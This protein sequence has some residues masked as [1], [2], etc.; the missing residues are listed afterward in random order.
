MSG[1]TSY[2]DKIDKDSS[3][4]KAHYGVFG[5]LT[6]KALGGNQTNPL[7]ST[8]PSF[9][10]LTCKYRVVV[11]VL[12]VLV[13]V[14]VVVLVLIHAGQVFVVRLVGHVLLVILVVDDHR[15]HFSSV[16]G[17]TLT[18]TVQCRASGVKVPKYGC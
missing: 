7:T 12:V 5:T 3:P 11:L 13:I 9:P 6:L 1:N 15:W 2:P 10:P 14:H 18:N 17:S 4:A 8:F 16:Q